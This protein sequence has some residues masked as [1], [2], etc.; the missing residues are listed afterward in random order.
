MSPITKII[1]AALTLGAVQ[2]APQPYNNRAASTTSATATVTSVAPPAATSNTDSL[3]NDLFDAPTAIK[4]FQR[5]LTQGKVL[6][7]GDALRKVIVF[8]FDSNTPPP[9]G[10]K[11]GVAVSAVSTRNLKTLVHTNIL[12]TP[13]TASPSGPTSAS[14]LLSVSSTPAA[15]TRPT[16]THA[17]PSS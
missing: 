4:R 12:P 3:F 16:C 9:A 11:G 7:T 10:A 14:A 17:P 2:A 6:F 15:S 1:I 8:P 5:L 13:L